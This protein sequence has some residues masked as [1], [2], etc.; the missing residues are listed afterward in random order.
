[1]LD[2][3]RTAYVLVLTEVRSSSAVQGGNIMRYRGSHVKKKGAKGSAKAS[4]KKSKLLP[5]LGLVVVVVVLLF[6][7]AKA[8]FSHYYNQMNIHTGLSDDEIQQAIE[9]YNPEDYR[10]EGDLGGNAANSGLSGDAVLSLEE[11]LR[12]EIE[13]SGGETLSDNNIINILLIGT[14]SR[15]NEVKSR[16]DTMMLVSVNKKTEEITLTSFA[17]DIYTYIPALGYSNRLNVPCAVGGPTML[18]DTMKQVFGIEI[19][20]YIMVNFFSFI[21]VVDALGGVDV[22]LREDEIEYLNKNLNTQNE[23]LGNSQLT[24]HLGYGTSGMVHLNGNQALAYAR[25]RQLDGD[26][27][28]T[29]RQRSVITALINKAKGLSLQELNDLAKLVLPMVTTNLTQTECMSMLVNA[30]EY[31]SYDIQTLSIPQASSSYLTMIDGMSVFYV[32][33]YA[34]KLI[35]KEEIF[36]ITE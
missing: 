22:E 24:D 11:Q 30:L 17:R 19:D 18:L 4:K 36:G 27:M 34:E 12:L 14:D 33:F 21:D 8:F 25:I 26:T 10:E 31:F 29:A 1:M 16:S 3:I 7:V 5:T 13:K 2:L 32:D 23:L 35:L 15:T 28:R 20:G 6:V 9:N